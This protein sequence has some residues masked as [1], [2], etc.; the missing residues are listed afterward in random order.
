MTALDSIIRQKQTL[1]VET[2]VSELRLYRLTPA[3]ASNAELANHL[4]EFLLGVADAV[5]RGHSKDRDAL[6]VAAEHGEQRRI[7]GYD[8]LALVDELGI[9]RATVVEVAQQCCTITI[10]EMERLT[11]I[12]HASS[13]AALMRF[14]VTDESSATAAASPAQSLDTSKNGVMRCDGR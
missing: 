9:L 2:F 11:Q 14:V 7:I 8:L 6:R 13:L 4:D 12:F 3:H 1:I 10:E 5:G